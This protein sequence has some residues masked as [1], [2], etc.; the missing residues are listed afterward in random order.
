MPSIERQRIKDTSTMNKPFVGLIYDHASRLLATTLPQ[1]DRNVAARE[2]MAV[3]RL[4]GGPSWQAVTF[5]KR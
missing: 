4:V 2:A 5:C 1:F 3:S